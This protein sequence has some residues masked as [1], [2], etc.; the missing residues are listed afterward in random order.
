[1]KRAIQ[2]KIDWNIQN[3]QTT[4]GRGKVGEDGAERHVGKWEDEG[5][6]GKRERRWGGKGESGWLG[7]HGERGIH[8]T[9]TKITDIKLSINLITSIFKTIKLINPFRIKRQDWSSFIFL[10]INMIILMMST[11]CPSRGKP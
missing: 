7:Q 6:S 4:D 1:M 9:H 2:V 5:G 8:E 11:G 3:N 10:Q